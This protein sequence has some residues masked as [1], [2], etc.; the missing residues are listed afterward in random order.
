MH[1]KPL[2]D[3]RLFVI[4]RINEKERVQLS[5]IIIEIIIVLHSS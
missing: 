4:L 1:T 5:I 2:P 3:G